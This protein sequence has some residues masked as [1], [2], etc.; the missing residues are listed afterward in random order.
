MCGIIGYV[1]ARVQGPP[2]QGLERLEYRGYDSA[3]LASSRRTASTTCARS[4][5]SQNL[6]AAAGTNGSQS[7]RRARPHALG[8]ARRRDRGERAPARPAATPDELSI[9]LNGIVENY[10]ELKAAL[11]A[12]GHTFTLRDGR[13]DGR[14]TWSSATTRATSSR[15]C[16]GLRGARGPLLLRRHPPRPPGPA[17]RRAA[18]D[19]L[20]VGLGEGETFLASNAAAFLRETRRVQFPDDG[21]IVAIT[22]EGACSRP[23]TARPSSTTCIELDWDDEGAEKGGYETFMLKEIHEQP[24]AVAETIGDRVRHGRLV[25]EAS[26]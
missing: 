16:G 2:L 17:R 6:K 21:E 5:T 18:P 1:G 12:E 20:V 14:R 3:G 8:D 15:P 10:R 25:L 7:R 26:A 4:A 23:S 24:E 19:P 22:P 13:R 9:V 11:D